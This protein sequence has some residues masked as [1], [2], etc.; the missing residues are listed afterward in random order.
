M[1]ILEG[2]AEDVVSFVVV[3]NIRKLIIKGPGGYE[4]SLSEKDSYRKEQQAL[5]QKLI[6]NPQIPYYEI[7]AH[8][9]SEEDAEASIK[10]DIEYARRKRRKLTRAD[11][12]IYK[13]TEHWEPMR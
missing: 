13:V 2:T 12:L 11:F 7:L 6:D 4:C 1:T 5:R 3:K 10:D 8:Y 9:D